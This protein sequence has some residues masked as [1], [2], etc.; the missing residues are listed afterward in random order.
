M[1]L[2]DNTRR[3]A[4]RSALALVV[5]GVIALAAGA[6]SAAPISPP[7]LKTDSSTVFDTNASLRYGVGNDVVSWD[8]HKAGSS[9]DNELLFLVY[10]RLVHVLRDGSYRPGLA[11]SWDFSD[12]GLSVTFHLQPGVKFQDG[13][14]FDAAAVKAN[15]ERAKTL[16]GSTAAASLSTVKSVEIVD[17]LTVRFQ[18]TQPNSLLPN[19]LADRAGAMISPAA[20]GNPELGTRPVGAG[21]FKLE[22][23]VRNSKAVAKRW[24]GYWAPE[25]VKAAGVEMF[26][27]QDE[28]ARVNA[29]LSGQIDAAF[30]PTAEVDRVKAA[31]INVDTNPTLEQVW[32]NVDW[33]AAPLNNLKIRQAIA[34]GIDRQGLIDLVEFGYGTPT[35]QLI[36]PY[37]PEFIAEIDHTYDYNP[38]KAL[39]LIKESGVKDLNVTFLYFQGNDWSLRLAQA[40][41]AQLGALGFKVTLRAIDRA[42]AVEALYV[43]KGV[44]M[45]STKIGFPLGIELLLNAVYSKAR[46]NIR[47]HPAGEADSYL[48]KAM[49][50]K[51]VEER[52]EWARKANQ[53]AVTYLPNIALYN[54][55][56]PFAV[57]KGVQLEKVAPARTEFYNAG[58]I[59]K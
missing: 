41:Q 56:G 18:L 21:M 58:H 43:K 40:V 9:R 4:H 36:H 8:P 23:Y 45:A 22:S 11:K 24:D 35:S 19:I 50:A 26:I 34:Y 5:S 6:A 48:E 1:R 16:E 30:I 47:N 32:M 54:T 12:D 27:M 13:T 53:E 25:L 14:D 51:S 59:K 33:G 46:Q 37:A 20:F 15:I 7:S 3:D 42:A 44:N 2:F 29:L 10:D 39:K 38:E 28:S 55:V 17:P 31:G 52:N 49:S 57:A